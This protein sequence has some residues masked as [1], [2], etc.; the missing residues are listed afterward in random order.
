MRSKVTQ[1]CWCSNAGAL[2]QWNLVFFKQH[3]A[4]L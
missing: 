1:I 2:E 3:D 4:L